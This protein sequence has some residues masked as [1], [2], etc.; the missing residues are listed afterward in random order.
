MAI[1]I[2]AITKIAVATA[3]ASGALPGTSGKLLL[4]CNTDCYVRF[5]G[6]TAT[7][8]AYDIFM[9]AG[10]A[11]VI[12]PRSGAAVSVIRDSADGVLSLHEID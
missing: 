7:S 10:S 2:G 8:A 3:A 11:F 5:D 6:D 12:R 4:T 1:Q 9:P